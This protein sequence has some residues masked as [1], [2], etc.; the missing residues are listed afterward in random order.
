MDFLTDRKP[1]MTIM[2]Q[3]TYLHFLLLGAFFCAL[4]SIAYDQNDVLKSKNAKTRIEAQ[5]T[6]SKINKNNAMKVIGYLP[7]F[8]NLVKTIDNL[9]KSKLTHINIA[10]LNPDSNGT[11]S[12]ETELKCMPD[13]NRKNVS[14]RDLDYVIKQA[15]SAGIKVLASVGGGTIPACSGDW[16]ELLKPKNRALFIK[17]I[18]Q[19]TEDFNLDGFDIDLEW[20]VLTKIDNEG[21]YTTFI[22]ALSEHFKP[23]NKLLTAAT[24]SSDGGMIPISALP[25]FDFLNIMSYDNIGPSWG[26]SGDEHSTVDQ[27]KSNIKVWQE[28]GLSKEKLVLGVPFYGYGFGKYKSDYAYK[29]ILEEFGLDYALKDSVGKIC[30]GCSYITYNGVGTIQRKVELAKELGSGIMI[31]ELSHDAQGAN[32]LLNVI[33]LNIGID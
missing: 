31:W 16:S 8:K 6:H 23:K 18:V 7:S 10:F 3:K 32:S 13:E 29:D 19:F 25:Y 9:D 17:K 22:K 26:M 1:T 33:D 28:R 30:A 21:N 12:G 24:A 14:K 11:F 20:K 27:A 5:F 15:H 2:R 4:E